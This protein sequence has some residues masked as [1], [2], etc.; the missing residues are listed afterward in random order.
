MR[1]RHLWQSSVGVTC[2]SFKAAETWKRNPPFQAARW[3]SP[4][5][6]VK[7]VKPGPR[8]RVGKEPAGRAPPGPAAPDPPPPRGGG[9]RGDHRGGTARPGHPASP[10][11]RRHPAPWGLGATHLAE[12]GAQHSGPL[13]AAAAASRPPAR[14]RHSSPDAAA[15][16]R[17]L[18]ATPSG[19][20]GRAAKKA[21]AHWPRVPPGRGRRVGRQAGRPA[22]AGPPGLKARGEAGAP[23]P[24]PIPRGA[25]CAARPGSAPPAML[26]RRAAS[27]GALRGAV[28]AGGQPPVRGLRA[29]PRARCAMP[30]W[31]ID[32][33]GRN[34]VLRFTRDMVFPTIHFPNEVIIKVHAASLN[35]ID[36]S[37]RSKCRAR[38]AGAGPA[39]WQAGVG[40]SPVGNR[41][42]ETY[43]F[44]RSWGRTVQKAIAFLK[45][46][47]RG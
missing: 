12:G 8:G 21:A 1:E 5:R 30:S 10:P 11:R 33:Y 45:T 20:I 3:Q 41:L 28:R 47:V 39:W 4:L 2:P 23:R 25:V 43:I 6:A 16:R 35:P 44:S 22:G 15:G 31:V 34:D 19:T 18:A 38:A 32:R 46:R 36:L 26:S 9:T 37:M 24:S 40:L 7:G 14:R 29:S 27:G 17:H 42:S 13:A